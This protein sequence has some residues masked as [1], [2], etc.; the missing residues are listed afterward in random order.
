VAGN[1][2]AYSAAEKQDALRQAAI[3][4]LPIVNFILAPDNQVQ[5]RLGNSP[6]GTVE[7]STDTGKSWNLVSTGASSQLL[8]GSAPSPRV[9]WIVGEG[10]ALL[11]TTDQGRHW[12]IL[13]TP[14]A[15]ELSGVLA[16]DAKHVSIW[17]AGQHKY[18]TSDG[19]ATWRQVGNP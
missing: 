18:Y 17:N 10:G 8:S 2:N 16:T 15:G 14:L 3:A 5:W 9:C 12:K 4:P 6:A 7:M 1:L 11:L 19:G 13:S